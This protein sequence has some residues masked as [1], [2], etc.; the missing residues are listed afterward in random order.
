MLSHYPRYANVAANFQPAMSE[1][2]L[3]GALT[4]YY[5]I[6]LQR[7]LISGNIKTTQDAINL[8]G[9]L[10]GLETQAER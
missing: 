5:Q 2:D 3:V 4:S 8:L 9:K 6:A 10:E 1:K 7:S